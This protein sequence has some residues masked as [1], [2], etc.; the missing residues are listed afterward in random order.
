MYFEK[1]I[2][3]VLSLDISYEEKFLELEKLKGL[4][5]DA[6]DEADSRLAIVRRIKG[7]EVNNVIRC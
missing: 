3:N 6:I 1:D 7:K 2:E 5:I 4:F